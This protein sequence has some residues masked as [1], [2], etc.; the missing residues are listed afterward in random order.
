MNVSDLDVLYIVCV[1]CAGF[2]ILTVLVTL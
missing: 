2:I 1:N